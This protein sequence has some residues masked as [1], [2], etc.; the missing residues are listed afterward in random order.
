MSSPLEK[1]D[2]LSREKFISLVERLSKLI[3]FS[4]EISSNIHI[5]KDDELFNAFTTSSTVLFCGLFTKKGNGL[6]ID[7][8]V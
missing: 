7:V 3:F 6:S 1:A 2:L 4:W 8:E 5:L